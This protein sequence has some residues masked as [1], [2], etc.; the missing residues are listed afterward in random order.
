MEMMMGGM[1][2]DG[3]KDNKMIEYVTEA[4]ETYGKISYLFDEDFQGTEFCKGLL[5]AVEAASVVM[6]F[7]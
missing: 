7:G 5:F 1:N 2:K 3:A 4:A 6:E